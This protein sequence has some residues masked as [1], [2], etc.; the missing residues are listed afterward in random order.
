M[1]AP[2]T[3]SS[4]PPRVLIFG[5]RGFMGRYFHTLYPDA[6]LSD[7]DIADPAALKTV[8]DER[9][10][11]VVINC[12]GKTGRPNVDWC[13]THQLETVH[14]NVTGALVLLEQA[15]TKGGASAT[16]NGASPAVPAPAP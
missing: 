3:S 10:P 12:A 16:S 8:F 6:V 9:R 4:S 14:G 1:I 2:A 13:E 15:T 5:G 11:D 7:A